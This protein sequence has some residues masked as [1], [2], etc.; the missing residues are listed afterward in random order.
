MITEEGKNINTVLEKNLS[1]MQE[2]PKDS[3]D[4]FKQDIVNFANLPPLQI[5]IIGR[6]KSGKSTLAK[7]IAKY[8]NLIY[9]SL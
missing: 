7:Q 6:A 1:A 3:N 2:L 4:P 9:I 8:Y 5:L